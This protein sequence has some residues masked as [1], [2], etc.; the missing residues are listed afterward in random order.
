MEAARSARDLFDLEGRVAIVT[1]GGTGIG[2]QMAEGLAEMG[3]DL[4]LCARDGDRCASTAADL[5]QATGVR[6]IGLA[7]D[8]RDPA[9]IQAVVDRTVAEFGRIDILVNNAGTTWAA[10]PQ[11]TTLAGWQKVM[12]V[13]LTGVFLFAQAAGRVMLE[14]GRGKII[15]IASILATRGAPADYVDAIAYNT[16]KGG[17]VT[18]TKD[19]AVKWG[20]LGVHVNGIAPGWFPSGMSDKA[21]AVR[22]ERLRSQI[23]LG[24]FGSSHDL[25]GAVVFLASDASDFVLG[26]MLAVDGG[27]LAH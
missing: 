12:D 8:A 9:A 15:N 25:K 7:C 26:H 19:L 18:F 24:R 21:F 23:P 13:N 22:G 5:A 11:D 27:D 16:S 3:A 14:Q 6:A 4:V 2:R 17:V 10:S 20:P 1:G